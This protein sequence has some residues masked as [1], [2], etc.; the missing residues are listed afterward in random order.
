MET[1][2]EFDDTLKTPKPNLRLLLRT[3]PAED[4]AASAPLRDGRPRSRAAGMEQARG[5]AGGSV[6]S[7]IGRETVSRHT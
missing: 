6:R 7:T 2:M 4:R 5:M 3:L 1:R